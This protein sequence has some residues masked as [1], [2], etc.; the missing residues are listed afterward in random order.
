MF[1]FPRYGTFYP[2]WPIS[3]CFEWSI[4]FPQFHIKHTSHDGSIGISTPYS[5]YWVIKCS[6]QALISDTLIIFLPIR[7]LPT[8]R[9]EARSLLPS[10]VSVT[11]VDCIHTADDIVKLLV[12][13]GRPI[14]L[15][16][17]TPAPIPIPR[18]SPSAR[19]QNT[20]GWGNW[21]FSTGITVYLG[22][23]TR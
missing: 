18:R 10:G 12:R 23:G 7:F 6:P 9:Y 5:F 19:A 17:L 16:F 8:R 22:N 15:V 4:D 21:R 2:D 20:R 14:T 11:L 13:P 3:A 1:T